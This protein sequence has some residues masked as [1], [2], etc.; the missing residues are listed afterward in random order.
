MTPE[1]VSGI[2]NR[3]LNEADQIQKYH[4]ESA[5][6]AGHVKAI[7]TTTMP[8]WVNLAA[9]QTA[10]NSPFAQI[11]SSGVHTVTALSSS[12]GSIKMDQAEKARLESVSLSASF[13]GSNTVATS[14]LAPLN[15]HTDFRV[16]AVPVPNYY[17]ANPSLAQRFRKIDRSL[18]KV[19]AEIWEAMYAT[20]ADPVRAATYM[21]R[22]TYDHLFGALA[23]DDEVRKSPFWKEKGQPRPDLIT[24][25]ERLNY[26]LAKHVKNEDAQ[27]LLSAE[28]KQMTDLYG[29]LNRAHTR[30]ELNEAKARGALNSLFSYL[31]SWADAIGI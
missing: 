17:A 30:G 1:E 14:S 7:L 20:N 26:A 25:E 12:L 28:F 4:R 21:L 10:A 6:A 16:D 8:Y 11:V 31:V 29:E 3:A 15:G 18:E 5:A 9:Q 19:C 23:P 13:F 27:K 22:Q 2:F 24:R